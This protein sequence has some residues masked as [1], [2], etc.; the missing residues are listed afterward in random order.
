[1]THKQKN[2]T[3]LLKLSENDIRVRSY[4]IW[5]R[6]GCPNGQAEQHWYRAIVELE[7][8]KQPSGSAVLAAAGKSAGKNTTKPHGNTARK[9]SRSEAR[10]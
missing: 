7:T 8:E 3:V 5:E 6:E 9:S 10:I 4:L 1:M 2:T